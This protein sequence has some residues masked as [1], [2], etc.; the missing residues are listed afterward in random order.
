[1]NRKKVF[2]SIL[3]LILVIV[4]IFLIITIRKMVIIEDLNKKSA[5]YVNDDNH[6]EKIINTS[7]LS[8][9]IAEYYCKGE[10]AV[11]ILT[12]TNKTT[13]EV[14]K[15]S[16]YYTGDV[17]NTY[18]DTGTDKVTYQNSNG[19]P[20]QIM[21]IGFDYGNS[22]WNLFLLAVTSS[23]KNIE[24]Q[25]KDCYLFNSGM[26]DDC[27]IEKETGLRLKCKNGTEGEE[28]SEIN[29]EYF[30]EFSE[31]DDSVFI[32]PDISEYRIEETNK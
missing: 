30:Y 27:I 11:V 24:Y 31:V 15:L 4:I 17:A 23:F 14:V 12:R 29:V 13:G 26:A 2:I 18:I 19:L 8:E 10:K 3:L 7:D 21:V 25:G 32:E 9:T 16:N 6:Y 28:K 1:M 20:S 5:K 22:I